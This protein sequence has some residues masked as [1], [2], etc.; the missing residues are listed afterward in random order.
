MDR[1]NK[2]EILPSNISCSVK[3]AQYINTPL[4]FEQNDIDWFRVEFCGN[5]K[6]V[7]GLSGQYFP[8]NK[9]KIFIKSIFIFERIILQPRS[10]SIGW[11]GYR[12]I[13]LRQVILDVWYWL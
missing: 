8:E 3:F 9:K 1:E 6:Y 7:N 11:I 4:L 10:T 12:L 13:L 5:V 2:I